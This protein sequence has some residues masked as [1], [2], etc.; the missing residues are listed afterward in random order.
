MFYFF[1]HL[2]SKKISKKHFLSSRR[3]INLSVVGSSE[4]TIYIT[5]HS[6]WQCFPQLSPAFIFYSNDAT[7]EI[8]YFA[9]FLLPSTSKWNFF[10]SQVK[11]FVSECKH[12]QL[13]VY[14]YDKGIIVLAFYSRHWR[15]HPVP[16][17]DA[18]NIRVEKWESISGGIKRKKIQGTFPKNLWF[19]LYWNLN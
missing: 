9:L 3:A 2:K 7:N 5:F 1:S 19:S 8:F 17:F 6:N 4:I 15:C 18:D 12:S 13:W 10:Y 14:Q 11:N 16:P